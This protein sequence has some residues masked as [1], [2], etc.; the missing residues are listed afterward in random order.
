M[1]TTETPLIPTVTEP[2]DPRLQSDRDADGRFHIVSESGANWFLRLMRE[3]QKEAERLDAELQEDISFLIAQRKKRGAQ[4]DTDTA[5]L[6]NRYFAEFKK[7]CESRL[8]L[9][10]RRKSVSLRFGDI[11]TRTSP[12]HVGIEN[13]SDAIQTARLICPDAIK[14]Y[15]ETIPEQVIPRQDFDKAALIKKAKELFNTEGK[16]LP[17]MKYREAEETFFY[18]FPDAPQVETVTEEETPA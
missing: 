8:A 15:E 9:E 11:G 10:R 1:T 5:Y 17:G 3:K 7:W 13:E 16:R 4:I 12:L 14:E 6:Q 2:D 18:T